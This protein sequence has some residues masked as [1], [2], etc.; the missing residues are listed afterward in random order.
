MNFFPNKS[1]EQ[2]IKT[3][4]L[5]HDIHRNPHIV[6]N[7]FSP[8]ASRFVIPKTTKIIRSARFVSLMSDYCQ[9]GHED[10]VISPNVDIIQDAIRARRILFHLVHLLLRF[11]SVR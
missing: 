7:M 6:Q 1:V 10:F 4:T 5:K 9:L 8:E 3:H 2:Y 11:Q